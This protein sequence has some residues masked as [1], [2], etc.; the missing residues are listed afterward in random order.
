MLLKKSAAGVI[1]R[2]TIGQS[3]GQSNMCAPFDHKAV[4]A[5][6]GM[7]DVAEFFCFKALSQHRL[8]FSFVDS[9]MDVE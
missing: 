1:S 9:Q 4:T 6:Q 2:V 3:A 8:L 7:F 5:Q